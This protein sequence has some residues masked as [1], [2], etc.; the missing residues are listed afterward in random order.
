M[1]NTKNHILFI[2]DPQID[3]I[4]GSMKVENAQEIMDNLVDYLDKNHKYTKVYI[5]K[6]YHPVNHCSFKENGGQWP[7][8]CVQ[9]TEGANIY[10]KLL[11][12]LNS[13]YYRSRYAICGKGLN[14][15]I[16]QYSVFAVDDKNEITNSAGRIIFNEMSALSD[17]DCDVCGIAG[18]YCVLNTLKDLIKLFGISDI[19][20][21]ADYCASTDGG[22]ALNDYCKQ[23]FINVIKK[24]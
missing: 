14:S 9:G 20:L 16:E 21:L 12:V 11:K 18:D 19:R 2:V 7:A 8:H 4:S 10:D 15:N 24:D 3:F 6:D 23:N 13:F 5:T 1:S 17:F 22:T